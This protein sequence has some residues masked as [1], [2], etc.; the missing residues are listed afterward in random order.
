MKTIKKQF[1]LADPNH[2]PESVRN[3][4]ATSRRQALKKARC[5]KW[6]RQVI[7]EEGVDFV[8]R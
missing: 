6:N 1:I 2:Y 4:T 5:R 7:G 3:V 8:V